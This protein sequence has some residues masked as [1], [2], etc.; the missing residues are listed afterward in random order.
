MAI[1]LL[2][3]HLSF[4]LIPAFCQ[5]ASE[6]EAG[7]RYIAYEGIISGVFKHTPQQVARGCPDY[8]LGPHNRTSLY[9]GKYSWDINPFFFELYRVTTESRGGG[10]I[11]TDDSIFNLDFKSSAYVCMKDNH[12]CGFIELSPWY[13]VGA[14]VLNLGNGTG[15]ATS[16]QTQINSEIG[17]VIQ[18]DERSYIGNGT[19]TNHATIAFPL[20]AGLTTR[21]MTEERYIWCVYSR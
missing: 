4:Y 12:T 7:G 11:Y 18:G 8:P 1:S 15:H 3:L 6:S 10:I 5:W 21:C 9:I 13:F 17:Y 19:V 2:L 20:H 14:E 16:Q